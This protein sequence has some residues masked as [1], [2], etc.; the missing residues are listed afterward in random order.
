LNRKFV[1][2]CIEKVV[3]KIENSAFWLVK[4]INVVGDALNKRV[5]NLHY[6]PDFLKFS[7]W[8]TCEE[9]TIVGPTCSEQP[10]VWDLSIHKKWALHSSSEND[11]ITT[12]SQLSYNPRSQ[13]YGAHVCGSHTIVSGV[14]QRGC[15]PIMSLIISHS[16]SNCC[17]SNKEFQQIL[18]IS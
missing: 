11:K 7:F 15:E 5:L 3:R 4:I 6:T 16:Y 18:R 14:V 17:N 2:V 10:G 8:I 12:P 1:R 9:K 13:W